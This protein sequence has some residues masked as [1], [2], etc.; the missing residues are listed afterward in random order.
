MKN[1]KYKELIRFDNENKSM[2]V[3]YL[4]EDN[5]IDEV[6]FFGSD[7]DLGFA[8]I[9]VLGNKMNPSKMMALA[10][11]INVNDKN[12]AIEQITSFLGSIK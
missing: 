11:E 12:V 1:S 3:T 6:L 8:L 5:A 2:Q 4:G 9:R 7:T 10:A